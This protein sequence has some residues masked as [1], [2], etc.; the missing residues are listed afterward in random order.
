MFME[1]IYIKPIV[2][3]LVRTQACFPHVELLVDRISIIDLP[4]SNGAESLQAYRLHLTD[5]E[6]TIQA[7]LKRR[8]HKAI[9]SG[10]IKEG[11]IVVLKDYKLARA[12]RIASDGEVIYLQIADFYSVGE[13][14][15]KNENAPPK[16]LSNSDGDN[17]HIPRHE[18]PSQIPPSQL[19][20]RKRD[21]ASSDFDS[22]L[23]K[24]DQELWNSAPEPEN[25]IGPD[26]TS[27]SDAFNSTKFKPKR[28]DVES[29]KE[30]GS[31]SDESTY[32]VAHDLHIASN[33]AP[34]PSKTATNASRP[35]TRPLKVSSLASM[36]SVNRSKNEIHD[37]L[38]LI[39]HV[40]AHTYKPPR[41][42]RKR[43]LR[44]MDTSTSKRVVLSVF[45]DPVGFEPK[46][47]TVAL[48]RN[49]TTHDWDGG[50]LKAYPWVCEG[51]AWFMPVP[52][53]GMVEGIAMGDVERLRELRDSVM[54]SHGL[55]VE[56][57]K[58]GKIS[59][60]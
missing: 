44:I 1:Q 55:L 59:R 3:E 4:F 23:R 57:A 50:N 33:P 52:D 51:T 21:T 36:T 40:D 17:T 42:P 14:A 2:R 15:R 13:E 6:K 56:D 26:P 25:E 28:S 16:L 35:I 43:D 31:F 9:T 39:V 38:A 5:R 60:H 37:I 30:E 11:S 34:S 12:K 54:S 7:V 22:N 19:L 41:M 53:D 8:S 10:E 18:A 29:A 20:K 48:F 58:Q 24:R 32:S 46:V 27:V 45:T 47:G 49:L